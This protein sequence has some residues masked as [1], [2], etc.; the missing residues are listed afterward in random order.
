M[1]NSLAEEIEE[2][3]LFSNFNIENFEINPELDDY[4]EN[5]NCNTHEKS[6]LNGMNFNFSYPPIKE[7]NSPSTDDNSNYA[8]EEEEEDNKDLVKKAMDFFENENIFY[9]TQTDLKYK[10]KIDNYI[11]EDLY[12]PDEDEINMKD[13]NMVYE[14]NES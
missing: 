4:N 2:G 14:E 12:F 7:N 13:T 6:Y 10:K 3:D 8:N 11:H 1:T 9:I 5:K